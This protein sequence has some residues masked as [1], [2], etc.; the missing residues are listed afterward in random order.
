MRERGTVV[1]ARG[2]RADVALG[3]TEACAGCKVCSSM[4]SA[5][6]EMLLLDVIDPLGTSVGDEVE[7]EIPERLRVQAALAIYVAPLVALFG[8]YLAGFLLASRGDGNPDTAGA[9]VGIAC[10]TA[11]LAAV[12]FRERQLAGR[13]GFAP[14]VRAIIA[15]AGTGTGDRRDDGAADRRYE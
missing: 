5:G 8:G 2:D 10:A 7:I 15:H 4:S 6:D 3:R 12:F 9:F 1:A 13:E 11:T 14:V